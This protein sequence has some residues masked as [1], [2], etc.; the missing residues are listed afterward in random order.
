MRGRRLAIA[1]IAVALVC[2]AVAATAYA[3]S[4]SAGPRPLR[5]GVVTDCNGLFAA[6]TPSAQAGAELALIQRGATLGGPQP[7]DGIDGATVAGRPVKLTFACA[8]WGDR[9]T[10]ITALSA[11][12][13]RDHADIVV[14]PGHTGDGIAVR[15]Y[16]RS[17]PHTVFMITSAE[18][19]ATLRRSAPSAYRFELDAAQWSAGLG[20]YGYNTLGWRHAITVGEADASGY[21]E[22]AGINAEFCSLGGTVSSRWLG[23]NAD[24]TGLIN[25][26]LPRGANVFLPGGIGQRTFAATWRK[27]QPDLGQHLLVGWAAMSA[28]AAHLGVVG[29]SPQPWTETRAW[30]RYSSAFHEAFPHLPP[31]PFGSPDYVALPT[32]DGV[33]PALEA[34]EQVG[35]DLSH[36]RARFRAALANLHYDSPS[37][38]ITLDRRHQA[39]GPMYL[40]KVVRTPAG[41]YVVRQ[42][43]VVKDVEQTFG[44]HFSPTT[45]APNPHNPPVCVRGNPPAWATTKPATR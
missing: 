41:R 33:E 11:L 16:A 25:H 5:I 32:Y 39:I 31:P 18:Q 34:L 8:T 19:S 42:I 36:R 13:E 38:P 44:G 45:P 43:G 35:G 15:E 17:H 28:D 10:T 1:A 37:G 26:Q 6:D 4:S 24:P 14:G 20:A 40:G 12:V 21:P 30:R 23:G 22:A 9:A 7:S 27:L 3:R 29:A 2:A